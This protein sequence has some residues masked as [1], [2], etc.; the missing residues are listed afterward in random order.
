MKI[1]VIG[2][3]YPFRGGLAHYT[4]LLVHHLRQK[5]QVDFYSYWRQY[6]Q[7]LFPGNAASDP[8]EI[9]LVEACERTID[10]LNPLTWWKTANQIVKAKPDIILLQWWT[11]FWLPL[12]FAVARAARRAQIPIIYLCHQFIEPDSGMAEWLLTREG[13]RL[14]DG[15]IVVTEEEFAIARRTFPK[16]PIK[17]GHLPLFDGFTQSNISQEAARKLLGLDS[18]VSLLLFFGFVRRYKGLPY[19]LEALSQLPD[20]VHLLI[21]GEFWE[22]EQHYRDL[23]QQKGLEKRIL[24]HNR[25]IRNEELEPYFAAA[26]ALVLP[27]LSGS[28]SAVGTLALH[29]GL[30]II[31][32]NVG[33]L[34]ETVL[35]G[36]TGLI[37][38][39]ADSTALATALRR[40]FAENLEP[41]LRSNIKGQRDHLSWAALISVIEELSNEL[42]ADKPTKRV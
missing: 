23:I 24:L 32:T 35:D 34:A 28:Q 2:P 14:G 1:A 19:L 13:L 41:K 11:P 38:P 6:P 26:N 40:F 3:T 29:Y 12:L 22:N 8:S 21:A 39:P 18:S 7:W 36:E 25:Y 20:S 37:V 27:Y 17:A 5:H 30:P 9:K 31:A 15:L 42:L 16:K 4:T 10:P 33:G